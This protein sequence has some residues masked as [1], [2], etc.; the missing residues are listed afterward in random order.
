MFPLPPNGG[1]VTWGGK[2][3]QTLSYSE[4]HLISSLDAIIP[5]ALS[6]LAVILDTVVMIVS[7]PI[8]TQI[9]PFQ[10]WW[11]KVTIYFEQHLIIYGHI[12]IILL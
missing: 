9:S 4:K 5:S 12:F 7:A 2:N 8:K 6:T 10:I 1:Y 11:M 3:K